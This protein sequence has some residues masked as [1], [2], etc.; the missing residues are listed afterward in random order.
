MAWMPGA[1]K[2]QTFSGNRYR[3]SIDKIVLHTT[4]GSNWPGYNG[5]RNAPHFTVNPK[6][7]HIRQ[8]I[9]T[10]VSAKALVNK[11]GGVQTNNDGAIQIE[12]IGSCDKSYAKKYNLAFVPDFDDSE[13]AVIAK[14]VKWAADRYDIPLTDRD[15]KWS[16]SNA[17]YLTAPQRMSASEWRKFTGV[18][19]HQHVPENTHWDPGKLDVG[20]IL[21]LAGGA[22]AVETS[23][24]AKD[25]VKKNGDLATDGRFGTETVKDFQKLINKK[26]KKRLKIDG[27]AGNKTWIGLQKWMGTKQ[28]GEISNQSYKAEELGN[29]ITQGWDYDGPGAKG[30]TVVR[31]LQKEIGVKADGIW[32]EGTTKALQKYI[33][34]NR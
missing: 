26:A 4:E 15:L 25:P 12:I 6:T 22:S 8:H 23:K 24:P 31:A 3:A 18:C 11:S 9:D 10:V 32:F 2:A 27:K 16:D 19:G 14:V 5:G 28:D 21:Q 13:L 34:D 7:G 30:S 29:G 1:S 20:R 33:N 17:A